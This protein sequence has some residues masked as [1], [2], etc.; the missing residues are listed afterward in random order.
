MVESGLLTKVAKVTCD[1]LEDAFMLTNSIARSWIDNEQVD[2][3]VDP[4]CYG[5]TSSS[6]G[7]VFSDES[8]QLFLVQDLGFS[9]VDAKC[10]GGE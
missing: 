10:N 5:L 4:Q 3:L 9:S 7:D 1:D 6:P 8:G 2:L